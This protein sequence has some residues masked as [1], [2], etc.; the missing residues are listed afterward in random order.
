MGS[1]NG[2]TETNNIS[3]EISFM[4]PSLYV[5]KIGFLHKMQLFGRFIVKDDLQM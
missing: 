4:I 1:K 5:K 3:T 2:E